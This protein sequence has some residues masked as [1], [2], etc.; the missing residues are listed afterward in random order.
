[1]TVYTPPD[2]PCTFD[3]HGQTLDREA[4]QLRETTR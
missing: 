2:P 1:M 3:A 4:R